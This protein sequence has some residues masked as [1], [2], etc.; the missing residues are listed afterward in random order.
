M[1]QIHGLVATDILLIFYAYCHLASQGLSNLG[2]ATCVPKI[3]SAKQRMWRTTCDN[4]MHLVILLV[5][6]GIG[7][8][9]AGIKS[10]YPWH[11]THDIQ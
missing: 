3:H 4:Q 5:L 2:I 6:F 8:S 11:V 1:Q 9:D 7:F 10:A